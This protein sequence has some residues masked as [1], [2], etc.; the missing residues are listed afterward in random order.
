M[1]GAAKLKV[2]LLVEHGLGPS[3]GAA[4]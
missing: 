1:A 2:P 4:H 3:W